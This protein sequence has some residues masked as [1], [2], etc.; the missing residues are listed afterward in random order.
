MQNNESETKDTSNGTNSKR[1]T[2]QATKSFLSYWNR[3]LWPY[4]Y[5]PRKKKRKKYGVLFT[6]LSIRAVHNKLAE[7]LNTD[8]A[9]ISIRRMWL[10]EANRIQF[11]A[12]MAQMWHQ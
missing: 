10:Q 3:L 5:N 8:A 7:S 1:A 12:I 9:F 2:K 6:C 11:I 4:V